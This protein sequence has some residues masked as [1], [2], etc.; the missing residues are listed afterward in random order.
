LIPLCSRI[1]SETFRELTSSINA[2]RFVSGLEG[3]LAAALSRWE[4]TYR[5]IGFLRARRIAIA[6]HVAP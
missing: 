4:P 6:T 5:I 2:V 1:E 3:G